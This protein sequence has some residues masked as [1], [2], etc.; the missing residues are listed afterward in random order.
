MPDFT[1]L[2]EEDIFIY[3]VIFIIEI[4]D[5]DLIII[6]KR[7]RP[8]QKPNGICFCSLRRQ[9][10]CYVMATVSKPGEHRTGH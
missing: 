10:T 9:S 7:L 5:V 6:F 3:N 1:H 8:N 2:M 4:Y